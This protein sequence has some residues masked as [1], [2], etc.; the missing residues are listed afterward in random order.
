[1]RYS[2]V[3]WTEVLPRRLRR[4]LGGLLWHRWRRPAL[5]RKTLPLAVILNRLAADFFV[6]MPFGRRISIFSFLSKKSA[7]YSKGTPWNQ[8]VFLVNFRQ[9]PAETGP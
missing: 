6:L 5:E 8:A 9:I 2:S 1:M 3:E 7:Q 4:R